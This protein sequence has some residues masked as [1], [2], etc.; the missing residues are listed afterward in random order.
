MEVQGSLTSFLNDEDFQ[1]YPVL[2][3]LFRCLEKTHAAE[4]APR[5]CEGGVEFQFLNLINGMSNRAYLRI[6][7]PTES[8]CV[9]LFYKKSSI[10]FSRDR[11]SYGGVVIDSRSSNRFIEKDVAEWIHFLVNGLSPSS[12]PESL[13][14]SVP[15]TIPED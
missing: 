9:L 11:F 3:D 14:K 13:K 12:R 6:Y 15:Y 7:F 5:K 4:L 10:P 2:F 8:K 1:R